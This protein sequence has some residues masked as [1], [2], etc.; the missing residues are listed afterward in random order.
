MK[1][2][3]SYLRRH[4]KPLQ[5]VIN[6]YHERYADQIFTSNQQLPNVSPIF[7]NSHNNGL[8]LNN[9]TGTQYHTI[10]FNKIKINIKYDKDSF[11]ITKQ[12]GIVKCMN[13]IYNDNETIIAGKMYKKLTPYFVDPIDSTLLD[14]FEAQDLSDRLNSWK[15]SEIKKKL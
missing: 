8:L 15:V 5:Q 4:E 13:F 10:V 1:Q 12:N 11:I 2:L 14:I 7:K 9:I 6:R 3:K